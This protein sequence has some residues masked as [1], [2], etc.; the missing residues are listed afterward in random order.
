[1]GDFELRVSKELGRG[2]FGV[3]YMVKLPKDDGSSVDRNEDRVAAMKIMN[4]KALMKQKIYDQIVDEA[5]ILRCVSGHPFVVKFFG[6]FQNDDSIHLLTEYCRGGELYHELERHYFKQKQL[7][8][9]PAETVRFYI[10]QIICALDHLHSFGIAYRDLKA[11]NILI[12]EDGYLRLIDFGFATK[13]QRGDKKF[14]LCGTPEYLAPEMIFHRGYDKSVDYWSLGI[15][16]YELL[17]EIN[18]L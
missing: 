9:L 10:A 11:E 12:G 5:N 13:M 4:K 15:L 2:A 1:M 3:V 14:D 16:L 6:D 7:K 18:M 8:G 17:G